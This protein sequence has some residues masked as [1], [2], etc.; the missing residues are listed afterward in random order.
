MRGWA[1][2]FDSIEHCRRMARDYPEDATRWQLAAAH[3]LLFNAP[4]R[5][6][7]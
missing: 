4:A 1:R 5:I 7:L 6:E 2:M 3:D